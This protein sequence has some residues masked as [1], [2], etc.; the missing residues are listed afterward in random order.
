MIEL[1]LTAIRD[2]PERPPAMQRHILTML[3]LRM[4]WATGQGFAGIR[5]LMADADA[6]KTTVWRA[7]KWAR[8]SGLLVCTRRGHYVKDGTAIASQWQLTRP[9]DNPGQG[10]TSET[11]GQSQGFNGT[12]PKVSVGTTHQ[13]SSTSKER[14]RARMQT[15]PD[16]GPRTEACKTGDHHLCAWSWC[17]CACAHRGRMS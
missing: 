8:G 14:A 9:V 17:S 12:R 7:T 6:S 4:N 5:D 1:W 13:E 11:L 16:S 3:A 15:Q 2:H 10:F